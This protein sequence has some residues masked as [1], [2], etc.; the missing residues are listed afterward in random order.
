MQALKGAAG[1]AIREQIA[2]EVRR[3]S[4]QGVQELAVLRGRKAG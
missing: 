3:C 1:C 2:Q 4:L